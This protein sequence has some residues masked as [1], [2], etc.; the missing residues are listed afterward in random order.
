MLLFN[1]CYSTYYFTLIIICFILII[2][3]FILII[4]CL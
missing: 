4:N 2:F 1:L 3:C